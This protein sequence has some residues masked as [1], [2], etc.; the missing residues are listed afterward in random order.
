MEPF[1]SRLDTDGENFLANRQAMLEKT[2]LG[3]FIFRQPSEGTV[4]K[5]EIWEVPS[6]LIFTFS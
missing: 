5:N 6:N 1:V 2:N 3:T 4:N